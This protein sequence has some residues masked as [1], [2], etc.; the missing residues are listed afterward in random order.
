MMV[1]PRG[2]P[3]LLGRSWAA[4]WLDESGLAE[5]GAL[6]T[7]GKLSLLSSL[8]LARWCFQSQQS[9]ACCYLTL[10]HEAET[11]AGSRWGCS[12]NEHHCRNSVRLSY[13]GGLRCLPAQLHSVLT[14]NRE[15]GRRT[16]PPS[17][18][19]WRCSWVGQS[20]SAT[21]QNT[22]KTRIAAFQVKLCKTKSYSTMQCDI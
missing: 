10:A 5:V 4:G 1:P 6:C 3:S 16:L 7:A 20:L 2:T 18:G 21:K 17:C 22:N 12:G 9:V 19:P 15:G 11:W 14:G 13:M 8:L